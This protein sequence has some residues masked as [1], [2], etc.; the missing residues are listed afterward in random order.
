MYT[1]QI[2]CTFFNLTFFDVHYLDKSLLDHNLI[3][4]YHCL[5]LKKKN[6]K[7]IIAVYDLEQFHIIENHIFHLGY[8]AE[9]IYVKKDILYHF[10]K[11]CLLKDLR[12]ANNSN[13]SQETSK[14]LEAVHFLERTLSDAL[15]K[16]SS[17]IHIEPINTIYYQ[18]R[19]RIHG[20]LHTYATLPFSIGQQIITRIKVISHLNTTEQ[21]KPQDGR[22]L[23]TLNKE[24]EFD[25][26]IATLPTLYGEKIVIRI[27]NTDI[28]QFS[29]EQL[30]MS[31][32]QLQ[33]FQKYLH[34]SQGMIL[35][36]GPTGSGKTIT[37][38]KGL[39]MIKNHEI[40]ISTVE[41]PI[42]IQM[43][44]INQTQV[45]HSI[46]LDFTVLL[47]ALLRQDPDV[48][49]IGEIRDEETADIAI[50]A[51]QTGHLVLSTLHTNS[52]I[53]ALTRLLNMGIKPYN[54]KN[55]IHLII[56]QR[57]CRTLCQFCKKVDHN[58][59]AMIDKKTIEYIKKK[60]TNPIFYKAIGCEKCTLG[61]SG[62]IGIY[63]FL[64][65]T[66]EVITNIIH[67]N[68]HSN[69]IYT[70]PESAIDYA[71]IGITSLLEILPLLTEELTQ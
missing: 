45:N 57:L 70:I 50:K 32:K 9:P 47:R 68:Y 41:D 63:E 59:Q 39:D 14:S 58:W 37:L 42:E 6:N 11:L 33:L 24:L 3:E 60:N 56:A 34:H 4:K 43:S 62:R 19:F 71:L 51:S 54:F 64:E 22:V 8:I 38:Y 55:T 13:P 29:L 15:L 44:G 21:R 16:Q 26:R 35:V 10:L 48:I 1:E 52:A 25:S 2:N 67:Q 27:L 46:G 40:N 66:D 53:D 36:T 12:Y 31:D 20:K 61:F 65:V 69:H 28:H 5:P 23:F 49:M 30:G 17:D 7:M 18:F